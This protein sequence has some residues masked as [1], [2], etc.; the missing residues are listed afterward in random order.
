MA[1]S[2]F[3]LSEILTTFDLKLHEISGFFADTPEQKCSDLLQTI[4]QESIDLA[5]SINTEK[6]RSEMIIAPILLEVRRNLNYEISLFSGVDFNV[7][8]QQGLNGFCDF[9][10]SLSKEQLFITAPVVTLVETKNENLKLGLG[11]CIAEMVAAQLFNHRKGNMIKT[12]YGVVT[13]GTI[14]QFLQ[15]EDDII[16]IDLSEYYI[17]DLPKILGILVRGIVQNSNFLVK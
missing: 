7:D 2:D 17:K 5:I 12:I 3:R 1:Y 4:L 6:A 16:S 13:I 11:Q 8:Q 15:L 9:M 14:W 10:I